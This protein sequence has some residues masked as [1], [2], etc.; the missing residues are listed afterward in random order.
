M[1]R[2]LTALSM[3]LMMLT[4]LVPV[5]AGAQAGEYPQRPVTLIVTLPAGGPTD[6]AARTLATALSQALG[7]P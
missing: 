6:A 2:R 4:T 5:P 7:Q 3:M 1:F